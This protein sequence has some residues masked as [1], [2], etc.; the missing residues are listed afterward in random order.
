MGAGSSPAVLQCYWADHQVDGAAA[1]KPWR[2]I[3][4]CPRE[5]PVAAQNAAELRAWRRGAS[6]RVGGISAGGVICAI[7]ERAL[8][9][10]RQEAA[11]PRRVRGEIDHVIRGDQPAV[12]FD[13]VGGLQFGRVCCNILATVGLMCGM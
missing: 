1:V 10:V 8:D 6:S 2:R 11:M 5:R 3:T 12:R 7:L 4:S 9:P 13:D